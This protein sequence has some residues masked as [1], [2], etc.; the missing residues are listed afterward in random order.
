MFNVTMRAMGTTKTKK[1]I[2]LDA[3]V[4][5]RAFPDSFLVV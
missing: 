1:K 3:H 4:H 5:G 2:Q